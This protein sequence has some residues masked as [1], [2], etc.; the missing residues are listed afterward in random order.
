[1]GERGRERGGVGG[2]PPLGLRPQ[3]S[4][5]DLPGRGLGGLGLGAWVP[6][7][8]LCKK[9]CAAALASTGTPGSPSASEG[10]GFLE[11]TACQSLSWAEVGPC[12]P[13]V[14]TGIRLL[15]RSLRERSPLGAG[16]SSGAGQ[17]VN[18]PLQGCTRSPRRT[19]GRCAWRNATTSAR[20]GCYA[21]QRAALRPPR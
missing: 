9:C 8:R 16:L 13:R 12:P 20:T 17:A 1:M 6:C 7:P 5:F 2:E 14:R 10:R 21:P 19:P 11:Y 3:P 15:L 4:P 18:G